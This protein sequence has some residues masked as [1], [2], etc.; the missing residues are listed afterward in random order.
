MSDLKKINELK[1]FIK[2]FSKVAIAFSGGVDSTFLAK[3]VFQE[4]GIDCLALTIDSPF[5]PR[6]ELESAVGVAKQIGIRHQ[7]LEVENIGKD[8]LKNSR[9]R[10]YLC[11]KQIF[12]ILLE[13]CKKQNLDV[14]FDGSNLDDLSDF[15]PGMKA[16]KE[17]GIVSPLISCEF[18]KSDIRNCSKT[19]GLPTWDK[20]S[21]A[22]LASRIPYQQVISSESLR[23]VEQA[24]LYLRS[25]GFDQVR[26]RHHGDIARIE[27]G[28][29][30]RSRFF[31]PNLLDQIND[32]IR[33]LG[34]KYI[35]LD[36]EGYKAGKLN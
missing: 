33:N 19:L 24:E 12:S 13:Q 5:I 32:E 30:E 23:Q 7:I 6:E 34:F 35:T 14:L 36:L 11:K 9:E 25:L 16:L 8:I 21:L 20:P 27:V 17:L 18:T 15:R 28:G 22:C 29:E 26:V 1:R 31:D 3:V 4:K 2:D 10:C